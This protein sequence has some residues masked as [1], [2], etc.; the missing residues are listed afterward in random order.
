M[1]NAEKLDVTKDVLMYAIRG[2][3]AIHGGSGDDG[4][5]HQW[6]KGEI[7]KTSTPYCW[8]SILHAYTLVYVL[9]MTYNF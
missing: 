9:N 8:S 3:D 1:G 7:E 6:F 5:V 2:Q 4:D